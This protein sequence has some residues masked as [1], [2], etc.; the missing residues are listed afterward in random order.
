MLTHARKHEVFVPLGSEKVFFH[1]AK[2][3][4]LDV[5]VVDDEMGEDVFPMDEE[6]NQ[7][8]NDNMNTIC[9]QTTTQLQVQWKVCKWPKEQ[10][11]LGYHKVFICLE[12]RKVQ[13]KFVNNDT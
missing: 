12:K 11:W 10:H 2:A 13:P 9:I 4:Q 5:D 7:I 1:V 6:P 3:K 8:C